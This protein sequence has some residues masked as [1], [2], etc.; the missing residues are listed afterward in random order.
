MHRIMQTR[1]H[2]NKRPWSAKLTLGIVSLALKKVRANVPARENRRGL[3][4]DKP[5]MKGLPFRFTTNTLTWMA[6]S[7]ITCMTDNRQKVS[8]GNGTGGGQTQAQALTVSLGPAAERA[9]A[10]TTK[11]RGPTASHG[12]YCSYTLNLKLDT[13]KLRRLRL[14]TLSYKSYLH[15]VRE[16]LQAS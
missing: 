8:I 13:K 1:M 5:P 12:G 6:A 10:R 3:F 4:S 2:V 16:L 9:S 14:G 15:I 11:T 7:H